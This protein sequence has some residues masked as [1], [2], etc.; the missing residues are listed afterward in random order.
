MNRRLC[1]SEKIRNDRCAPTATLEESEEHL[2][3]QESAFLIGSHNIDLSVREKLMRATCVAEC[4][5]DFRYGAF[6]CDQS[7]LSRCLMQRTH[8]PL[9]VNGVVAE[10]VEKN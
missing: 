3:C 8:R 7:P 2:S 5:R 9:R 4:R 10:H 1:T 6:A